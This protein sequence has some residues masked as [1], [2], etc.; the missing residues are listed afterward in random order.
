MENCKSADTFYTMSPDTMDRVSD[1]Y[2]A[3]EI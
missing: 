3:S 2:V 1:V